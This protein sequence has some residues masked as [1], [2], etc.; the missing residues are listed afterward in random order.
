MR[1]DEFKELFVEESNDNAKIDESAV[2]IYTPQAQMYV[3]EYSEPVCQFFSV[4][5]LKASSKC[6]DVENAAECI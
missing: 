6:I 5:H 2:L 4:L 3:L 1:L